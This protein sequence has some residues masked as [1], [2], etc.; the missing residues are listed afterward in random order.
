MNWTSWLRSSSRKGQQMQSSKKPGRWL[1]TFR[2]KKAAIY[3]KI[4]QK[5]KEKGEGYVA[6]EVERVGKISGVSLAAEK[7]AELEEKLKILEI[8]S[9]FSAKEEL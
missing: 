8:F 3:I 2:T 7:K 5:I 1:K 9:A 6:A 4:M